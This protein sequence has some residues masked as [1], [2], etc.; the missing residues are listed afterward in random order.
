MGSGWVL[1]GRYD[2]LSNAF[3][4]LLASL[5]SYLQ[6]HTS[7]PAVRDP[8]GTGNHFEHRWDERQYKAFRD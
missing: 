5:A 6:V 3:R 2:S 7:M 8:A 1:L 4:T